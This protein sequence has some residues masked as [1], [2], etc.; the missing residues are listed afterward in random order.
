MHSTCPLHI[1]LWGEGHHSP[2]T[3]GG[4]TTTDHRG[5]RG[6]SVR[7]VC[8]PRRLMKLGRRLSPRFRG[9]KEE[10]R[11]FPMTVWKLIEIIRITGDIAIITIRRYF[12][13]ESNWRIYQLLQHSIL[14]SLIHI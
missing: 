11:Y 3:T 7:C 8:L 13:P 5:G 2:K 9:E 14:L 10:A 6:M 1:A 4:G 12:S